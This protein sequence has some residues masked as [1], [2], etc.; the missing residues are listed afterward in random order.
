MQVQ[1]EYKNNKH[2]K[3]WRRWAAS[4]NINTCGT[5]KNTTGNMKNACKHFYQKIW[6]RKPVESPK[7][8]W[9][10]IL[11]IPGKVLAALMCLG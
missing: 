8:F 9:K 2:L 7:R 1:R 5:V 10:I 3:M 11:K 6:R 4:S